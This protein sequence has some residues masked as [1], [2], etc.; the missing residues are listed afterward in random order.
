MLAFGLRTVLA[1]AFYAMQ[2][3]KTPMKNAAVGMILNIILNLILSRILG[4]GG[5]AL[6]TS[7]AAMVTTLLLFY[8]LR[9]RIGPFGMKRVTQSFMKIIFSSLVM[10]VVAKVAFDYFNQMMRQNFSL[11]IAV[12]IGAGLYFTIIYFMKIEEVDHVMETIRN[13]YIK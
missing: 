6:A 5:L 11:L 12:L 1:R 8:S 9:K 10:G 3:T 13:R 4:L 7:I 2:D